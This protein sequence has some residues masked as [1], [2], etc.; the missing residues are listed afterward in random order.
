MGRRGMYIGYW[1]ESQKERDHWED[2]DVC[3]WKTLK[4]IVETS[5]GMVWIGLMWLRIGT[6]EH[7]IERL[8]TTKC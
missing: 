3:A 8:V 7:G 2:Q 4:W 5:D 6:R 1:W